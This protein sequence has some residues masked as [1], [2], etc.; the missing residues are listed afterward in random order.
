MGVEKPLSG[1]LDEQFSQ[2]VAV[3][4]VV[5]GPSQCFPLSRPCF[6]PRILHDELSRFIKCHSLSMHL[7]GDDETAV[8]QQ[9]LLQLNKPQPLNSVPF[10]QHHSFSIVCPALAERL[11]PV[12]LP[13]HQAIA[14][15]WDGLAESPQESSR[16]LT[17]A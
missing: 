6:H 9:S 7:E 15:L 12:S 1:F 11:V 8:P 13:H 3:V 10:V 5:E 17:P 16:Q 2:S 14:W 4:G